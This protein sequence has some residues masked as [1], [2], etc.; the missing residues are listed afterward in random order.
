MSIK[1]LES[2][3]GK[4]AKTF[5]PAFYGMDIRGDM[6]AAARYTGEIGLELELEGRRLPSVYTGSPQGRV[7]WVVHE[8]GSLRN[9]GREY[10]LSEPCDRKQVKPLLTDL[11][12]NITEQ[13]GRVAN[14]TRCST[15]VHL[16]MRGVKLN[17]LA[18]FVALWGCF[19][20]VL[21][22]YCGESRA[23]NLF[24]LRLSDSQFAVDQ[25]ERAFRK[26]IFTFQR[27]YRYLALN[28]VCLQTFGSLEVRTMRGVDNADEAVNWVNLLTALKD[29]AMSK[30]FENPAVISQQFSGLGAL[31]L[32]DS[33]FRSTGLSDAVLAASAAME[34]DPEKLIRAGF[35]RV[36]PLLYV[37]P[38]DEY[39][40]EVAK[41][42][43]PDPFGT[44]A[45]PKPRHYNEDLEAAL[46]RIEREGMRRGILGRPVPQPRWEDL[47]R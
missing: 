2:F 45:K 26:G 13:G 30:D 19:E 15:H 36:Q 27:E 33:I 35:R 38:W 46:V 12:T 43:V 28:P 4:N 25:W 21:S 37:L 22:N 24:A 1:S 23:G 14:S 18:S 32:F 31:G 3:P 5:D 40:A 44:K 20:D 16:N 8:D 29:V 17:Q 7:T 6:G 9:G 11:F 47:P 39:V 34:E 10:V 42:F 41:P